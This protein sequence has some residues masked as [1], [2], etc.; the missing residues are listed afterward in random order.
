[1]IEAVMMA[2]VLNASEPLN[3]VGSI[4]RDVVDAVEYAGNY[5]G[6]MEYCEQAPENVPNGLRG[7]NSKA[8]TY[9]GYHKVTSRIS[10]QYSL[11]NSASC[12]TDPSTGIRMVG[13]RYC[14]AVGSYYTTAIGTP[15]NL[16]FEDGTVV[17]CILGD[18]KADKD[19]NSTNQ[20]HLCDGSVAEFVVDYAV[21]SGNTQQWSHA[22]GRGKIVKVIVM[23]QEYL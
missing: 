5:Y 1:M 6:E 4:Y 11:L 8:I 18:C 12:Y 20:F 14:I 10:A 15:I 23:P 19:T 17:R 22:I 2:C 3:G 13:N 9:M 21:F 7:C 16:V